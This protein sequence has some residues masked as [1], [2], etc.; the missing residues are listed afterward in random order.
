MGGMGVLGPPQG[1]YEFKFRSKTFSVQRN[2]RVETKCL[3]FLLCDKK[4]FDKKGLL[5]A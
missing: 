3:I 4:P 1:H 5:D 2:H